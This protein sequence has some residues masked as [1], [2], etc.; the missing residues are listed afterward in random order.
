MKAAVVHEFHKPLSLE[1]RPIPDPGP[2][3]FS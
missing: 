1:E 3:K 2:D